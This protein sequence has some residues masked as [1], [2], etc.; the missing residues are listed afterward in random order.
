M[1]LLPVHVA[2]SRPTFTCDASLGPVPESCE[3]AIRLVSTYL[4]FVAQGLILTV[5]ALT[6]PQAG[7]GTQGGFPLGYGRP[8]RSSDRRRWPLVRPRFCGRN[9]ATA[10]A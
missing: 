6:A 5:V 7:W 2:V 1:R 9:R 3:G 8:A 10:S 4:L